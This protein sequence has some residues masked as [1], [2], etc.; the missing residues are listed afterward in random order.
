MYKVKVNFPDGRIGYITEVFN[1]KDEAEEAALIYWL[2][3]ADFDE[4][5]EVIDVAD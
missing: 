2:H 3:Q 4:V 1:T 5:T